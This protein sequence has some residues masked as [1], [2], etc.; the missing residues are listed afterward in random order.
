MCEYL[1]SPAETLLLQ[2]A[3]LPG[4]PAVA[5]WRAWQ[6][7]VDFNDVDHGSSRLLPLLFDNL[8]QQRV[9]D[10]ILA[11]YEGLK[12]LHWYHNQLLMRQLENVLRAFA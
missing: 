11:K 7:A 1:P 12:K 4:P 5:A 2:A 9:A 10:P 3:L 6:Q 8:S